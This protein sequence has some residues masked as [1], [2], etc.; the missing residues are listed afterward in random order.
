MAE[1]DRMLERLRASVRS[2]GSAAVA[3]S[4]GADSTLVAKVAK[5]ELGDSAVAVTVDSPLMAKDELRHAR[6][7]AKRLGLRHVVARTD[8]LG[9]PGFDMNPP[10]RCYICKLAT[11]GEVRCIAG[12]LGLEEVLDGSNAD[13]QGLFRPGSKARE[14]LGVRSPLAEA[15]LGK[16]DVVRVS[17]ALGLPTHAKAPSPCLATR[18]PYGERLTP[19]LLGRIERAEGYLARRGFDQVRVRAHG[20]VARIEV[21]A[22][23]VPMLSRPGTREAVVRRLKNLGFAYVAVDLEGYRSGSMDEV[24][25]R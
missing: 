5:D 4:G 2:A 15:G 14:E 1:K 8:P 6:M 18:V 16:R 11:F 22:A 17:K 3:F 13:D 12:E 25:G 24:I 19:E 10:D 9:I 21:P 20:D 23:K 7:L